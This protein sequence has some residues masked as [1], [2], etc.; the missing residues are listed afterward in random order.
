MKKP[1]SLLA[2][3][4]VLTACGS[5]TSYAHQPVKLDHQINS[6]NK[7]YNTS[8]SVKLGEKY[9]KSLQDFALD[10]YS[11]TDTTENNVFSPLS[12]AT[13]F[14]MLG[15]GSANKTKEEINKMLHY[16]GSFEY[17]ED[18]KNML[19][20]CAIDDP[21]EDIYL[22][23]SQS[24]WTS[25]DESIKQEYV[26]K[27]TNYYYAEAYDGVPFAND[28]AK[29]LIADWIN[30]KTK[31]FLNVKKEQFKDLNILTKLVLLNALYAKSPWG[32]DKLFP[33]NNNF[34]HEFT[35]RD[36]SKS[37]KDFMNGEIDNH[38]YYETEK[39]VISSLPF[40]RDMQI[41]FLLPNEG[42]ENILSD[43]EA[44]ANLINYDKLTEREKATVKW[45]VPKFKITK[46]YDLIEY[47]GKLGLE[48]TLSTSPDFSAMSDLPRGYLY[49]KSAQHGAGIELDN[50]GVKAAAYTYVHVA[51]KSA[52]PSGIE[53]TLDRPFAY[54]LT[55]SEG[56]P[57]MLGTIN[58]F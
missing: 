4:M 3:L 55:T 2:S 49:V 16:D 21:D 58:A 8:N 19:A 9:V 28:E 40:K 53:I 12:I 20:R 25:E 11:I 54:F 48:E 23:V 26:D 29:Q 56:L 13:C 36:G 37:T 27:L 42:E 17:L 30:Q 41:N 10:F 18:I 1:L 24:V 39:Y 45:R 46:N 32:I 7:L 35:N 6:P 38:T 14:S 33:V 47:L 57:L 52:P 15:D 22:D 50:K 43:K 5:Q 31:D 44:I 34:I 51:P